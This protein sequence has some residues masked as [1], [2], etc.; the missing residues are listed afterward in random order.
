VERIFPDS[1]REKLSIGKV[2]MVS[3]AIT[4]EQSIKK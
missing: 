3:Y 1:M 2:K 4:R